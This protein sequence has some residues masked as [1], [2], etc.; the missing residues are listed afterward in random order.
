M[1]KLTETVWTADDGT[2]LLRQ[3]E[4]GKFLICPAGVNTEL[5]EQL[6]EA[7]ADALKCAPVAYRNT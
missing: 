4:S 5:L 1:K 2:N 7:I 3:T 6:G